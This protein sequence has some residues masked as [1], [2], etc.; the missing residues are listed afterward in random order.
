MQYKQAE[1]SMFVGASG[2]LSGS[3]G[4]AGEKG[5]R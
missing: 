5:W 2:E 3:A 1:A 4:R